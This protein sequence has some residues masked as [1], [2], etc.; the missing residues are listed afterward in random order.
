M[1]LVPPVLDDANVVSNPRVIVNRTVLLECPVS[2]FPPPL[3]KWMKNGAP[4]VLEAGM[5]LINGG[6]HVE[7]SR[8]QQSDA[9]QYTCIALNEAGELQHSYDLEVL[10]NIV[11]LLM[12]T[13]FRFYS[14]NVISLDILVET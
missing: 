5:K 1:L 11:L 7:I 14:V 2:G 8:V 12:T 6:R 9:G 10:G 4:L 13:I 3:V